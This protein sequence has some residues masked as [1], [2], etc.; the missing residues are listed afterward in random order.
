MKQLASTVRREARGGEVNLLDIGTLRS[1]A[2][3]ELPRPQLARGDD[4][5][6]NPHRDQIYQSEL[7]ELKFQNSSFSSLSSY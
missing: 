7:F 6:G 4:T 3:I 5:V 2:E 1:L